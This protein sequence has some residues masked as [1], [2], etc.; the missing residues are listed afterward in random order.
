MDWYN[1]CRDV[2]EKHFWKNSGELGKYSD[3]VLLTA[4]IVRFNDTD[5]YTVFSSHAGKRK[6]NRGRQVDRHW[7]FGGIERGTSNAFIV[8]FPDRTK[9]NLLPIIQQYI[10]P[11][12]G[13][14]QRE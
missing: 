4:I 14:V 1:F 8:V 11:G 12:T 10:R 2:C 9:N 13:H 7:E 6:Y 3:Y 5:P